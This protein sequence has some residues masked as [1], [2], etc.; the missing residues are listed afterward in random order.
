MK[1]AIVGG[2]I[3]GLACAK[4]LIE[5]GN[6]VAVFDKGKR[7]GGRLTTLRIDEHAW[8][9]GAP[10]FKISDPQFTAQVQAWEQAGFAARWPTGPEGAWVGVPGMG[11]LIEAGAADVAVQFGA[12]VLRLDRDAVGW[13]LTGPELCEGP[14]DAVVIAVP[15][16]QAA[17]LL[18]VH[19]L[20]M[21]QEAASVR[22]VPCWSVMAA[23]AE[24]LAGLPD[25]I[26]DHGPVRWAAR[27]NS[28]PGRGSA[29]CWVIQGTSEWSRQ[30]LEADPAMVA[31]DL[32][33]TLAEVSMSALPE[34]TF[35]KAHRWR[36][37]LPLGQRGAP[38]W[39][40]DLQLGACGDWCVGPQIEGAWLSGVDLAEQVAAGQLH[41]APAI[42]AEPILGPA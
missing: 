14:F 13:V 24:P 40:S 27:D 36:F 19:D 2:G 8:D 23:F 17:P 22:S 33:Q 20:M 15:C 4:R 30:Q 28:K 26:R 31:H 34:P 35:L 16:E 7:P 10:Y 41:S 12:Q 9:F 18:A 42:S 1:V 6:A 3:A 38:L 11:A 32:L 25:V 5:R 39:N 29:E 21:A 37:A